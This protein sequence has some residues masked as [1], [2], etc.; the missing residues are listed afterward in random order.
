MFSLGEI[1]ARLGAGQP[2]D[3]GAEPVRIVHDSREIE[4]GDLFVAMAGARVDGHAFL[5]EAFR[6][7]ACGAILS[8]PSSA[9]ERA[10]GLIVV[11]DP[12]DALQQLASAW[13]NRLPGTLIG[14]TGSFGKTT[15][16]TLLAHMLRTTRN[17]HEPPA[18][19]NTEIGLPLALLAMQTESDVG[20]FELGTERPGEIAF[21]ASLLRPSIGI[22][23]A[24]GPS[25]L[26]GLGSLEA[27]TDEKWS[28]VD[29]LGADG[30]AFVNGDSPHL[31]SRVPSAP[32][33]IRSVGLDAGDLKGSVEASV[34]ALTVTTDSPPMR[35][36]TSLLGAQNATNMLLAVVCALHLGV[37]PSDIEEAARDYEPPTHRLRALEA[38]LG[39]ILD[40]VYNAN[41]ASTRA[42][43]HV[44]SEYGGAEA[45][46]VF[47]FGD[48]L[49][50]GEASDRLHQEI[51]DYAESLRID[52][53]L[54]VGDRAAAVCG[55][56]AIGVE[57]RASA[58]L[59]A[60]RGDENIVL[61]KGSRAL[62]LER[63]VD[64]LLRPEP[65]G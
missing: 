33:A 61:V 34:P 55:T 2:A 46:R 10:P 24:V 14:V 43:L 60:L 22:L 31:A 16:R 19:Y 62:G 4:Q 37:R 8:D 30:T 26:G 28:L 57:D 25:H 6:R 63:L 38:P 13:R 58:V 7:G 32:C 54:P 39:T 41:P 11:D 17:V 48:M 9:P 27:I 53:I 50:L 15:T 20:V 59:A 21:L 3:A 51:V 18:N 29:A 44:L 42:A 5:D 47:V 56:R 40:D 1:A 23:T 12:V 52:C 35:L 49:D 36:Q 64:S 45:N 65:A